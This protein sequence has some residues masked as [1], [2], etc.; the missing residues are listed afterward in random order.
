MPKVASIEIR[1]VIDSELTSNGKYSTSRV[2]MSAEHEIE[3]Y[4]YTQADG[5][6][7]LTLKTEELPAYDHGDGDRKENP[8]GICLKR[9]SRDDLIELGRN[10]LNNSP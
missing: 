5:K 1:E 3:D 4:T 8:C 6:I 7:I 9:M 10:L 2:V